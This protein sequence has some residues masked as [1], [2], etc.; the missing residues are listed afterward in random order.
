[1]FFSKIKEIN[2]LLSKRTSNIY[3]TVAKLT[4]SKLCFSTFKKFVPGSV[5]GELQLTQMSLNFRTSCCNLKTRD[6]GAKLCV[7]WFNFESNYGV[8][9]SKSPCFLLNK[10]INFNK[11]KAELKM[12]NP[13]HSFR[14]INLMLQLI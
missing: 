14:E 8:L 9:N 5:F 7:T 6:L 4:F 3:L 11:N 2:R 12:E 10:N 13:T 1:M